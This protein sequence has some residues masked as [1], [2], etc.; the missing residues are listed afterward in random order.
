[1]KYIPLVLL[2]ISF[3]V[4]AQMPNVDSIISSLQKFK[5]ES[6]SEHHAIRVIER[7]LYKEL[8]QIKEEVEFKWYLEK[9]SFSPDSVKT[10]RLLD[11][12]IMEIAFSN[13][14]DELY[15]LTD[16]EVHFLCTAL[17]SM[18]QRE[19]GYGI[20]RPNFIVHEQW[21]GT[22]KFKF[23]FYFGECCDRRHYTL[24]REYVQQLINEHL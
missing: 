11:T 4:S 12:I 1:M 13:V 22:N 15:Y 18:L 8:V 14:K 20:E 5:K 21:H 19:Y 16:S 9:L 23:D 6:D 2:L 10:K 3:N 7:Q 24:E 17:A